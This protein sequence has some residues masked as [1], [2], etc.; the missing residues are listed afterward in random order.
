MLLGGESH[1]VGHEDTRFGLAV[2]DKC[3][4]VTRAWGGSW[5]LL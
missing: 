2:I 3:D 5:Q 1:W 4:Y